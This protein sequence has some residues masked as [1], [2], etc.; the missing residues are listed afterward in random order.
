MTRA[1]ASKSQRSV[2]AELLVAADLVERGFEVLTPL[3]TERYDLVATRDRQFYRI[4]VKHVRYDRATGAISVHLGSMIKGKGERQRFRKYTGDEID[5]IAAYCPDADQIYYL[6]MSDF[7]GKSA[8]FLRI[9]PPKN[10]Q[11]ERVIWAKD[12]AEFKPEQ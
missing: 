11:V 1:A 3:G 10:G 12:F 9:E 7:E 8:A 4:Q 2:Q 6:R 5:F